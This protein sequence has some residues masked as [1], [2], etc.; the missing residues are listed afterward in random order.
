M[1]TN[2]WGDDS[3]STYRATLGP[4]DA[5]HHLYQ[6]LKASVHQPI[7]T[8]LVGEMMRNVYLVVFPSEVLQQ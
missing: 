8:R 4:G 5:V 7:N 2:T 1:F 3:D 6:E